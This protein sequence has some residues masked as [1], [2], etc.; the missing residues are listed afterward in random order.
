MGTCFSKEELELFVLGAVKQP[1]DAENIQRHLSRCNRCR[2]RADELKMLYIHVDGVEN[3][4]INRITKTLF[5]KIG[6]TAKNPE[7]LLQPI[8][9]EPGVNNRYLLAAR[10]ETGQ[11]YVNIQSYTDKTERLIARILRDNDTKDMTLYMISDDMD[12]CRNCI[13]SIEGAEQKFV[14]DLEGK[15]VLT[16]ISEE[17]LARGN[18]KIKAVKASLRRLEP[19][20]LRYNNGIS[21]LSTTVKSFIR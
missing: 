4:A 2:H 10:S 6:L 8:P 15:A 19:D 12:I 17:L 13:V 11:R 9:V 16:N 18:I 14:A 7:I 20:I 5:G 21:T 1:G 3:E